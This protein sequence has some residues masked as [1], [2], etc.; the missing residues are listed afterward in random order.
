MTKKL[1][2]IRSVG[3]IQYQ[4]YETHKPHLAEFNDYRGTVCQKEVFIKVYGIA[5]TLTIEQEEWHYISG[6]L[7]A[8][9]YEVNNLFHR[10]TR[11]GLTT[12]EDIRSAIWTEY[13]EWSKNRH[14][15]PFA[16]KANQQL[17]QLIRKQ[18]H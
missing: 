3:N 13:A 9:N 18:I 6:P 11:L 7:S 14:G 8:Q 17:R 2:A 15:N 1:L 10:L 5:A 16:K 12:L 4:I